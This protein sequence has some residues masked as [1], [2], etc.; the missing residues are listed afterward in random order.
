[1]GILSKI[2]GKSTPQNQSASAT[3]SAI[4]ATGGHQ[5]NRD[6]FLGATHENALNPANPGE[7]INLRTVEIETAP[8]YMSK[9]ESD[10]IRTQAKQTTEATGYTVSALRALSRIEQSNAKI[11]KEFREYQGVVAESELK[12]VKSNAKLG[13]KLHSLRPQY[14]RTGAGFHVA[15]K[16]ADDLVVQVQSDVQK[17]F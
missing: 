13:R 7:I 5:I 15:E 9:D 2:T 10:A 12:K 17:Y 6:T 11:Q 14:A 1:M 8:R 3:R 4:A 16:R